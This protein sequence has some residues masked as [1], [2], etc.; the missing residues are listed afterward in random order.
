MFVAAAC[1]EGFGSKEFLVAQRDLVRLGRQPF[2]REAMLK[3]RAPIDEWTTVMLAGA[4]DRGTVHLFAEGLTPDQHAATGVLACHD[5]SRDLRR[6]MERADERR[7]AVIPE[8]PYVGAETDSTVEPGG[9]GGDV[10]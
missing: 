9:D 5:L 10:A 8:G 2:L 4:A 1:Q 7:I 3:T 6:A